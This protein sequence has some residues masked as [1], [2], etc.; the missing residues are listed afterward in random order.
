M[1]M[2]LDDM[3]VSGLSQDSQA[4]AMDSQVVPPFLG[5]ATYAPWIGSKE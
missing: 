1:A 3:G 5:D 4:P 2:D